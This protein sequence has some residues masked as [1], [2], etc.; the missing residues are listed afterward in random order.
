MVCRGAGVASADPG[1]A[2]HWPSALPCGMRITL[3]DIL[4]DSIGP[5]ELCWRP[6]A[7]VG[8]EP[9]G[10]SRVATLSLC[11]SAIAEQRSC[12]PPAYDIM[13]QAAQPDGGQCCCCSRPGR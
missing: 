5:S 11:R 4:I 8:G 2:R 10:L 3:Y 7:L 9:T 6:E 13:I 1:L 12:W